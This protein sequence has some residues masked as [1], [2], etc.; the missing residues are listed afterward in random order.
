MTWLVNAALG[1]AQTGKVYGQSI[2]A[3]TGSGWM[4]NSVKMSESSCLR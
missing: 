2:G 3:V 4:L 1:I